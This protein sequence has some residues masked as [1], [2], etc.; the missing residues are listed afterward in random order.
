MVSRVVLIDGVT[1]LSLS[2]DIIRYLCHQIFFRIFRPWYSLL[3]EPFFYLPVKRQNHD[4]YSQN[5]VYSFWSF[6]DTDTITYFVVCIASMLFLPVCI[7]WDWDI[8]ICF[9]EVWT[10]YWYMCAFTMKDKRVNES[11]ESSWIYA[12]LLYIHLY[13]R[14]NWIKVPLF[15][16]WNK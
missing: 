8:I 5:S 14:T 7:H 4:G 9:R 15:R 11:L 6:V 2:V 16:K 10:C 1:F 3:V 13:Y 12:N